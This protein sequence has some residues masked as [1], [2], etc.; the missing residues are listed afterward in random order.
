MALVRDKHPAAESTGSLPASTAADQARPGLALHVVTE[1]EL[2]ARAAASINEIRHAFIHAPA[3]EHPNATRMMQSRG[4]LDANGQATGPI[5]EGKIRDLMEAED[6]RGQRLEYLRQ[7]YEVLPEEVELLNIQTMMNLQR[8]L[9]EAVGTMS[10]LP[11]RDG[12]DMAI[13]SMS[14]RRVSD[15]LNGAVESPFFSKAKHEQKISLFVLEYLGRMEGMNNE[16]VLAELRHL[17]N[18]SNCLNDNGDRLKSIYQQFAAEGEA[19]AQR[20]LDCYEH[21]G[22]EPGDSEV[23]ASGDR[24]LGR[25]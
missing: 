4:L 15:T 14:L 21:G 23:A 13:L 6:W 11:Y 17:K 2:E 5:T 9:F 24:R 19:W 3:G 22:D 1:Q 10:E 20:N 8:M 7:T 25:D 12:R 16:Q 18:L